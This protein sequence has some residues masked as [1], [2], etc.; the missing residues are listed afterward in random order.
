MAHNLLRAAGTLVGRPYERARTAIIRRDLVTMPA[1]TAC[2]HLT[3]LL[4]EGHHREQA[5]LN[6]WTEACAPPARAA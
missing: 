6:L 2:G 3:L 5:R 4:T 1:R